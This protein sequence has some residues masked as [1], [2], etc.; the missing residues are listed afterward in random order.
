MNGVLFRLLSAPKLI[1]IMVGI[2]CFSINGMAAHD[3]LGQSDCRQSFRNTVAAADTDSPLEVDIDDLQ[4]YPE[5]YYGKAV[6]VEGE[7]HRIFTDNVFTIED[8]GFFTDDDVLII[9]TVPRAEALTPVRESID[10]GRDV[11]VSGVVVP[12]DR[13][14][15]ECAY[16]P[17]NLESREGHSFT[18][19]P[20]LI[21]D[22]TEPPRTAVLIFEESA[23]VPDL[24]AVE[25]EPEA[26]APAPE[27]MPEP[28]APMPALPTTAGHLPLLAVAGLLALC[29]GLIRR[30]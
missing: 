15:L 13:G 27:P 7:M 12:Y 11:R 19:N 29:G 1:L 26:I 9:S 24:P 20:V 10:P 25:P 8:S 17:L 14:K 3:P 22:K 23:P 16:G 30:R 6:T 28:E 21:I 5:N 18:K 2:L 4:D